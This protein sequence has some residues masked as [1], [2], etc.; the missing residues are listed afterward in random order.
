MIMIDDN[1]NKKGEIILCKG[2]KLDKNNEN[3]LSY[4]E[5]DLV[6]LC[7]SNKIY[8]GSNYSFMGDNDTINVEVPYKDAMYCNYVAFKNPKFGNKWIFGFVTDVKL[9]SD[10]VT[11]ITWEKD[12]W[13]TWY[14]S[15]DVGK[16][17]I[18]R[19]HV[20]DDTIGKHTLPEGLETGEYVVN[21]ENKKKELTTLNVIM[22][23]NVDPVLSGGSLVGGDV[24]GG[25]YNDIRT[26][27]KY[28]HFA[29][30][31][32]SSLPD[33]LKAFSEAGKADSIISLFVAPFSSFEKVDD[34]VF[35]NGQVKQTTTKKTLPWVNNSAGDTYPTRL[36]TIDGYTPVNKKLLTFPYCYLRLTNNNGNDAIYHFEKFAPAYSGDNLCRFSIDCAITPGMSIIAYPKNYDGIENN[37]NQCLQAGK[38]PICGWSNDAYTNWLTQNGVNIATSLVS[39][40]LQVIGGAAMAGSGIGSGYLGMASGVNNIA[41][42]LGQ[43]YEHS[44]TPMEAKGNQNTGDV[45][46]ASDINT[47]TAYGM[48]IKKEYAQVIDGFWSK[49]GYKVNEVK[50]PNLKTRTQF[51]F[52]KVGGNDDLIHGNIPASD[53]E[54]INTIFRKGVTIFHSYA[55]FGNY[56]ISNPIRS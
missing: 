43:I 47:F 33:V 4:G 44:L 17:F 20:A 53:L 26:G 18:E 42:T 22:A 35:D 24:G 46:V 21:Y 56:T 45:K 10:L 54:K 23:S 8:R 29:N 1:V 15:F 50:Q 19:E 6:S 31:T 32:T 12:V 11:K 34:S 30:D 7:D 3:V 41:S 52:I 37:Y 38:Y 5:S 13:S 48:S 51:N 49:Y 27:F 9:M 36:S 14:S 16:A 39:S 25:I 2:I 55:N 28:Y 40:G